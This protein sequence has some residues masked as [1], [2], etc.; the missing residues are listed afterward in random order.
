MGKAGIRSATQIRDARSLARFGITSMQVRLDEEESRRWVSHFVIAGRSYQLQGFADLG[1]P[2]GA[3]TD[4]ILGIEALF[5]LQGFPQDNTV[6]TSGY[7]LTQAAQLPD[8]GRTYE[9]LRDSLLRY[10]R[11]GFIVR[12]GFE[13]PGQQ[14]VS[15]YNE[16]LGFFEKISFWER[17][18]RGG[19]LAQGSLSRD[20][21]LRVVLTPEF[22]DSLRS[23]FIHHLDRELL[24]N[25]EQP[26]ARALYRLLS[27]HRQTDDGSMQESLTV[28]L[29][30]WREA[31][32]LQDTRASKI[33]R[34]LAAAHDELTAL[35][36]LTSIETIGRGQKTELIYHFRQSGDPDP[37]LVQQLL[38]ANLGL[39]LVVAQQL[40]R[41]HAS[42]VEKGIQFVKNRQAAV[43]TGGKPV[44]NPAGLLRSAL[45]EPDRYLLN[46]QTETVIAPVKTSHQLKEKLERQE[47]E[48]QAELE[49]KAVVLQ[50]APFD[51]QWQKC[52]MGLKLL[53]QKNFTSEEW[54]SLEQHC[55]SGDLSAVELL[56]NATRAAATLELQDYVTNLKAQ[57]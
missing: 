55:M 38:D 22:A 26:P 13:V 43:A 20:K 5:A 4:V 35:G 16:T 32:G 52:R 31:C 27:A 11:T 29:Q 45:K 56:S 6:V 14:S 33:M 54:K 21:T 49:A 8:N 47:R 44:I 50:E 48:A 24:R 53:L 37:N 30:D 34:A 40:A 1:R 41:E 19:D 25:I 12:E 42:H 18:Q 2:R 46:Q 23:G 3:D 15:Y 10:W 39:S 36:Y 17:G 57:L 28:S 9:R 7:E 51:V